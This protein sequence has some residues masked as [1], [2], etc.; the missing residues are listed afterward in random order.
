MDQRTRVGI[1][2]AATVGLFLAV[3]L[4][5]LALAPEFGA[6][7]GQAT[8]DPGDPTNSLVYV[9]VLLGATAGMLALVRLGAEQ[10]IRVVVLLTTAMLGWYVLAVVLGKLLGGVVGAG[11]LSWLA[12][13]G[14]VL[15]ALGLVVHP[16]WYVVDAA[17]VLM[18]AGAAGLFGINFGVQPAIVLLVVLAV[19]D[20]ISVYGTGHMLT[21]AE[22][23][24]DLNL[25]VVLVVPTTLSFSLADVGGEPAESGADDADGEGGD[26]VGR[27]ALFVGLGD[28]VIPTII[29][30][31]GGFFLRTQAP[32]LVPGLALNLPA[33]GGMAG[34]VLGLLGLLHLVL[35][36]R[37]HAGLPLLNGGAI[38]GYLVG[39]PAAGVPLAT[40][41]G[42]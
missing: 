21:L 14:G 13:G 11:L 31:S 26:P 4:G 35:Q 9:G 18:G 29:V 22:G 16:E 7:G 39:A 37:P 40:A 33:L 5:A 41:L 12:L 32:S 8:E 19:Y 38:G 27:D 17:G 30:A 36:G 10:V 24:M 20:A 28:A 23:V 3:Q 42:L 25:P 2:T 34:T 6:A 15:V 1:A